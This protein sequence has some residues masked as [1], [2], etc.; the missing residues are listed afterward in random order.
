MNIQ[1]L[2]NI[3]EFIA[4]LA[5]LVT[6]VYLSLQVRQG[7]LLAKSQARQRMVEQAQS[8]LYTQ[9][10][11]PSITYAIVK[12]GTLTEEEQAR[13]S[14]FLTAFMRQREWEWYQ[15]HDGVIDTDVYRAYHDV[16]GIFLS[17]TRTRK[18]WTNIGRFAFN[19]SFAG[20]V[21]DML[22]RTQPNSYMSDIRHWDD[23]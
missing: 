7:N 10:A 4:A 22:E 9:M 5:V 6:L 1:D 3:G 20:E 11:D 23:A 18:W 16:I 19:E 2:G 21:D 17:Q 8:E 12:D 15:Y 13:L 14:M